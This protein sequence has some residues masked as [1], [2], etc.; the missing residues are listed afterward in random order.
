MILALRTIYMYAHV[1]GIQTLNS[2]LSPWTV[3]KR[4]GGGARKN[5][6]TRAP[7]N[8]LHQ[9]CRH[10]INANGQMS[11]GCCWAALFSSPPLDEWLR[12]HT[13]HVQKCRFPLYI[14]ACFYFGVFYV[15]PSHSGNCA[16]F[17]SL[18]V[19]VPT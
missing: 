11:G 16:F 9:V 14:L 2:R 6:V 4:D 8:A 19:C 3:I 1:R 10:F 18:H 15:A 5:N 13:K 17:P 7:A 12:H